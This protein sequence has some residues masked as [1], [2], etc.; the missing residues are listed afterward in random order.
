[1]ANLREAI[2]SFLDVKTLNLIERF[3][4]G[5]DV[6]RA[7]RLRPDGSKS[8]SLFGY[9]INFDRFDSLNLLIREIFVNLSYLCRIETDRPVIFDVGSNIGISMLFFKKVYPASKIYC[10]EPDPDIFD[11]LKRNI[12]DNGLNDVFAMNTGLSDSDEE[13][14]LFVPSWSSGSSS[15]FEKKVMIEKGFADKVSPSNENLIMKKY[16]RLTKCSSFIDEHRIEN[17]NLLKID[18]E[19]AEERIIRELSSIL[20][21]VDLIIMEYHYSRDFTAHNSM[22]GI[23]RHL[24]EAEFIVSIEPLWVTDSPQVMATYMIKAVNGRTKRIGEKTFGVSSWR[25]D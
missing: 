5:R 1:M 23:I 19:G 10:F 4:Y 14:I 25:W 24:E 12:I 18:V 6:L 16:V 21:R 8:L 22:S 11:L 15:I 20:E 13:S 7:F 3:R 2:R 17:I 9:K